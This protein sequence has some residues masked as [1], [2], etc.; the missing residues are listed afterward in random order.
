M[1]VHPNPRNLVRQMWPKVK[2]RAK[3][4]KAPGKARTLRLVGIRSGGMCERC[5][6]RGHSTHHLRNVSQGGEWSPQNCVRLC[7]SG[8]TLCHGW[9]TTHSKEAWV[10][11]FHL[12][13]GE[14]P[15]SRPIQSALH[16]VVYLTAAGG[17]TPIEGG[18]A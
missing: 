4:V 5:G 18:A 15:G 17:V 2:P 1:T 11:G 8:S 14:E 6:G 9:V 12:E 10:E 3:K 7:G 13:A 16:G